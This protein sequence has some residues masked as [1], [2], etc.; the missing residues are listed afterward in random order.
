MQKRADLKREEVKNE[1]AQEYH[2][3]KEST[4]EFVNIFCEKHKVSLPDD[5]L[6]D[7]SALFE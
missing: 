3:H 6:F 7:L 4:S 5:I 1:L 2:K